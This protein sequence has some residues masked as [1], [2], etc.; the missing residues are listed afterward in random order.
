MRDTQ[1][2]LLED[3]HFFSGNSGR[4][5]GTLSRVV[6]D[7]VANNGAAALFNALSTLSANPGAGSIPSLFIGKH[8]DSALRARS[9]HRLAYFVFGADPHAYAP[10]LPMVVERVCDVL[11]LGDAGLVAE[12]L[13]CLRAIL[14]RNGLDSITAFR[15]SVLAGGGDGERLRCTTSTGTR[16]FSTEMKVRR[17]TAPR[18]MPPGA[19]P[20]NESYDGCLSTVARTRRARGPAWT[21]LPAT[22]RPC[23]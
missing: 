5:L 22:R 7:A 17:R 2:A 10:Q 12:C 18:N 4:V 8:S 14:I 23:A 16:R 19:T 13:F 6:R 20:G 3:A 21:H 9:I 15:A 11:R 1:T